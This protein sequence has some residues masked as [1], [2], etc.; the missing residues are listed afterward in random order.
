MP[1]SEREEKVYV[2]F[3]SKEKK[4]IGEGAVNHFTQLRKVTVLFGWI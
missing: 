4:K 3:L 2:L 1:S